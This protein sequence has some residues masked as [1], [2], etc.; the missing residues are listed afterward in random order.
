MKNSFLFCMLIT[1][2]ASFG[3]AYTSMLGEGNEWH[4]TSCF[5]GC[6]T[7]VYYTDGDTLVN[8]KTYK[9]LEGYHY[10]NRNVL[11][12]ESIS[13]QKIYVTLT[14]PQFKEDVVLYDFSIQEG[15][16]IKMFNPLT[17]FPENGGYFLL[18]SI[19][20]LPLAD[21]NFYNHFYF[22]PTAS[23]S[24]STQNAIWVEGVGSL[25]MITAPGGYPDINKVGHLSCSFIN[26]QSRYS[27]LDSI[28]SCKPL[29]LNLDT[30]L[31]QQKIVVFQ[32]KKNIFRITP[33]QFLKNLVVYDLG[34]K[35]VK[36]QPI[37]SQ[38]TLDLDLS[39]VKSGVYILNLV[40][41]NSQK[42][43]FKLVVQ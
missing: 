11:L 14:Q 6:I 39:G 26:T 9:I 19:K 4:L 38:N 36:K 27:N 15:D 10:I 40:Q 28:N 35:I 8:G 29:V 5:F 43:V 41:K 25:S 37:I 16:S 21:G 32:I 31:E 22:T 1:A 42:Q 3:Q 2:F 20:S 18:D 23:N 24:Q 34:G 33:V 30:I 13:E 7:D 12:R 17:P